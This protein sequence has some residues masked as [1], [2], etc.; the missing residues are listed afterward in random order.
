MKLS[1][2]STIRQAK[3]PP[4]VWVGERDIECPPA[5]SIE[6]WN[7]MKAAG[8]P[9]SLV[10]YPGEGHGVRMPDHTQDVNRRTLALFEKYLG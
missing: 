1:P 5:Q 3:T 6:F 4:F 10:I 7:G 2:I 9:V 8:A